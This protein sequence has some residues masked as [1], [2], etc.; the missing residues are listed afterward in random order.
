M[1]KSITFILILFTHLAAGQSPI[2]K[3]KTL[4]E[5]KRFSEA[6]LIFESIHKNTAGYAAARYYLGRIGYEQKQFDDAVDFLEE[7]IEHN[8]NNGDYLNALGDTYA[9]KGA[10]GS[11][12]SQMSNG[13]K[14]LRAWEDA[15]RV[16]PKNIP[17]RASLATYYPLAPKFM[18]G[19]AEKANKVSSELFPLL[20]ESLSK[21]PDNHLH[22]Y[23]Y[24]R[25]A[26][27]YGV[28]LERGEEC[29]KK[30]LDFKLLE[31]EPSHAGANMRLGQIKEKQG[32]KGEARKYYQA[33][34]KLDPESK[35]AKAGLERTEIEK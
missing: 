15:A 27:V 4:Y 21:N 26:A 9:A 29:L 11:V 18:G 25:T 23:W 8:P 10:S 30:Y 14:A 5:A 2:D 1:M 28:N 6:K 20:E 22:V 12:F 17:A 33:A 35:E 16:D 32:N 31:G 24:G 7:A 13:P 19:G 34:L 3:A